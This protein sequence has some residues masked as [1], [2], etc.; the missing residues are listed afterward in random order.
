MRNR[1]ESDSMGEVSL[2]EDSWYGAQ[3]Q[4]A[5]ENFGVSPFTMPP[6]FIKAL[7]LVKKAAAETNKK[8]GGLESDLADAITAAAD[9]IIAGGLG[10][11]FPV[12]VFQTGSGTS[13]NMNMN[14]VLANRANVALG[15]EKG[16]R[17]PVHP[18]DHVNKGQSSNDVIPTALHISNRLA[19]AVLI[20]DLKILESTLAEKEKEFA[21]VI[22]LGRTHLQ[23]AVPMTLGQEFGAFREQVHKGIRRITL[24]FTSL[25]ELALGGTAVGSGLNCPEGFAEAAISFI[26]ETT[27][28]PFTAAASRFEAIACRD[29][30]VELMGAVNTLAVSLGK[31]ADD[32]RLL[33]SGPRAGLGEI[34]LPAL[35]PGSSIMPGKVNPVMP[36]MMIQAAA[37]A[38]GMALSVSIGGTNSPLQL[39]MMHPLIAWSSLRAMEV[40]GA[41]ARALGERCVAG[42][43]TDRKRSAAW[44]EQSL[45]LVTPLALKIGYDRAAE[46][47]H[48]AFESGKTVREVVK[49][50]GILPDKEVDRLLDPRSMIRE[51]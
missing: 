49:Q 22:K 8:L 32:L 47:A 25:E 44:I 31:I 17:K 46:L 5:V 29:A 19:A 23:D 42:I 24:T 12:D 34:S 40:L 16:S 18:N 45:A 35:Q 27:G 13:S 36:E 38:R 4:R 37:F 3:T 26:A 6:S 50:A 30:Q 1:T 21:D 15:G 11:E 43:K 33:S 7:A 14:E 2:P 20:E 39:N 51:E 10:D 41:G 28:I 48:T 9:E